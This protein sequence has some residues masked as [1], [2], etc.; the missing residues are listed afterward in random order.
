[1]KDGCISYLLK[2]SSYSL[3]SI[4]RRD[5]DQHLSG[6]HIEHHTLPA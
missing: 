1:M 4:S 6:I 2:A 5:I 3:Y